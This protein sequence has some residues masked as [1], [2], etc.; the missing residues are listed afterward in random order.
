M[1][2][3]QH[4]ETM[5]LSFRGGE[6]NLNETY[7]D[8]L[9]QLSPE[10]KV[11][12]DI[13]IQTGSQANFRSIYTQTISGVSNSCDAQTEVKPN[14][15]SKQSSCVV[16]YSEANYQTNISTRGIGI[17]NVVIM[18]EYG[19]E[20][21]HS[22]HQISQWSQLTQTKH[23]KK[24]DQSTIALPDT[25]DKYTLSKPEMNNQSTCA[26]QRKDKFDS[27]SFNEDSS[28]KI[29]EKHPLKLNSTTNFSTANSPQKQG[30]HHRTN[31]QLEGPKKSPS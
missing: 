29:V 26:T 12:I 18:R 7:I 11:N 3:I 6:I 24:K 10:K 1:N 9:G 30:Y 31:S 20:V 19:T 17:Q 13:G 4:D 14:L 2:H 28:Q 22:S 5:D 15:Q 8:L 21:K 25:H 16:R 23:S 27:Q